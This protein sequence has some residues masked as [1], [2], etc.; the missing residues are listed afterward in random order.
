MSVH[1]ARSPLHSF[2]IY[3]LQLL[4]GNNLMELNKVFANLMFDVCLH[5]GKVVYFCLRRWLES[6]WMR[7]LLHGLEKYAPNSYTLQFDIRKFSNAVMQLKQV[8]FVLTG[9]LNRG[10][11]GKLA[12][13]L[14][15]LAYLISFH[16]LLLGATNTYN[17]YPVFFQIYNQ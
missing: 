16:D 1:F 5:S 11:L 3:C 2:S 7:C 8:T 15:K 10:D 14:I 4:P 12:L 6:I 17:T 9:I 13:E